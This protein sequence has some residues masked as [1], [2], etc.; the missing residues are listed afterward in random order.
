MTVVT[1]PGCQQVVYFANT[2]CL[3]CGTA[4]AFDPGSMTMVTV[5]AA[6]PRCANAEVAAC[7]WRAPV[8]GALCESCVLTRTRP[9]GSDSHALDQLRIA[10]AAKRRLIF[11][12]RQIGLPLEARDEQRGTGV[13]FD[14]LSS[15]VQPVTT[16]HCSVTSGS[17]TRKPWT[18]TTRRAPLSSGVTSMSASTP[19]CTRPRTGR[20]PRPLPA[21]PWR[22]AHRGVLGGDRPGSR[23]ARWWGAGAVRRSRSARCGRCRAVTGRLVAVALR[24]QRR[25]PTHGRGGPLTASSSRPWSWSSWASSTSGSPSTVVEVVGEQCDVRV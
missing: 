12:L 20:R 9:D 6:A 17:T 19:R 11:Q 14:L 25:E 21:H 1:C 3:A 2:A 15:V 7:N 24:T 4:F 23:A 18:A 5:G 8:S 10:A 22:R 16:G 13:A